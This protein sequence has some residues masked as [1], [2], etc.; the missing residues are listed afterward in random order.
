MRVTA[1]ATGRPRAVSAGSPRSA[2]GEQSL[3][4]LAV[5]NLWPTGGSHRG[6]FVRTGVEALRA[7]GHTVDVEV[8]AQERGRRDYLLGIP[9]VRRRAVR[10]RYDIVHIHFGMTAVTARMAPGPKVV[11]LYGSDVN[12]RWKR[13]LTRIGWGGCAARIYVS[14]RLADRAGDRAAVVIPNGVDFERFKPGDRAAARLALGAGPD[15]RVILF[16]GDPARHVKGWD[17]FEDVV[18]R[19]VARGHAARALILT[20]PGQA[21]D[22]VVRKFDAADLLLFTSRPG[23]E[24]SPTVVKEAIAMNLPVVAVDVGDVAELLRGVSDSAVIPFPSNPDPTIARE[25]LIAALA[26]AADSALTGGRRSGGR[27]AHRWLD[28]PEIAGRLVVVYRDIL[29]P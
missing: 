18:L 11:S 27:E 7:L 12:T 4:V 22:G 15:E 9:R 19:L 5:T 29:E 17:V 10:G 16:G 23:S 6:S 13:W 26:D 8:V 24:G 2:R 25:Q 3:R 1:G 21:V 28:L 20:E 14:R